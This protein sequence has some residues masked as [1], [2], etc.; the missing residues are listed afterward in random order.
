M[1]LPKVVR[2]I[3]K[4][5]VGHTV[6]KMAKI[7]GVLGHFEYNMDKVEIKTMHHYTRIEGQANWG[8]KD[9]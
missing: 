4:S 1:T 6:L 3:Q 7:H 5:A 2:D 9:N 8:K